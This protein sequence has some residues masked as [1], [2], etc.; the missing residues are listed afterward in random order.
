MLCN[1]VLIVGCLMNMRKVQVNT[2]TLREP[3][4]I[5]PWTASWEP[6][7]YKVLNLKGTFHLR[8]M[9]LF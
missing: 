7:F 2:K 4:E 9:A 1:L 5:S 3:P 8:H 6:L